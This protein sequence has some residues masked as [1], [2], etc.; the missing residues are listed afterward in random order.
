MLNS[1]DT[2]SG[3]F[4]CGDKSKAIE[5]DLVALSV[6]SSTKTGMAGGVA[7][8]RLREGFSKETSF[9]ASSPF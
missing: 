9:L 8:R 2:T 6:V 5:S 1:I 3:W 4:I 7:A